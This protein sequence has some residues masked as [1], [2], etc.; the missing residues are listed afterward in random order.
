MP[1]APVPDPTLDVPTGLPAPRRHLLTVVVEDYFQHSAFSNLIQPDRWRR[2]EARV[3][4]NT[5]RALALL[6]EY[7]IKATFFTGGWIAEKM[8]DILAEVAGRGHEVA[9]KG[10]YH[11]PLREMSHREFR[12]DLR[13]SRVAIERASGVRCWG[14]RVAQGTFTPEDLWALDVL[15]EEGFA[16]DSSF[17]PRLA[18]IRKEPWRRYPHLH[19]HAG[20]DLWEVPLSSVGP[21][22]M[23]I[24]AAGGNYFRQMPPGLMRMVVESWDRALDA[25][26]NLYFHVW[27]LDPEMPRIDAVNRLTRVRQYRNLDKMEG[28]LRDYFAR[29]RFGSIAAHLGLDPAAPAATRAAEDVLPAGARASKRRKAS[30]PPSDEPPVPITIVIP[31]FNE[32]EAL[33]YLRNTLDEAMLDF[34]R[35]YDVKFVF[36]DDGSTDSTWN[37]LRT[38]FGQRT[39]CAFVQQPKNSGVAAAI[40]AGIRAATTEVV[41]SIDCDCTYDPRQLLEMIPMMTDG[42]DMV[43][44]SPY[45]P[46]GQVMNVPEWRLA[47]SKGLSFLY[48]R[49]LH[50]HLAT[51]TACFR[52]YR[53]SAVEQVEVTEGGYLGVVEMLARMDLAGSRIVEAPAVLEVRMMG[54]SKMKVVRTIRGHLGLLARMTATRFRGKVT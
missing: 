33:P 25:P 54:Q 37:V 2:F 21:A 41:C 47:L 5:R 19:H 49:L 53:R 39:N 4:T 20:H 8:P 17:F 16:Y 31:L 44:A 38:M 43:T 45:H 14:H 24:P 46:Q 35:R 9:S 34:Y 27:E 52:V 28:I 51:Y 30:L 15:A 22:W 26:F 32:E 1:D 12:D 6:D 11:R 40:L 3:G 23:S 48:R 13:R 36:V 50:N 7:D 10:F 18:D 42:V 29:Y